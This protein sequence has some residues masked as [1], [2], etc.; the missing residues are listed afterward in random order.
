MVGCPGIGTVLS[1]RGEDGA[2]P[3]PA[4]GRDWSRL[5]ELPLS[6]SGTFVISEG[7]RELSRDDSARPFTGM[8]FLTET[9]TFLGGS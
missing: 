2:S 4:T 7:E 5:G 9:N 3:C 1:L 6:L 8:A